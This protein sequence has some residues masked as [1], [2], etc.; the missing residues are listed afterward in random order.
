[1]AKPKLP[2]AKDFDF[3]NAEKNIDGAFY[4]RDENGIFM[5]RSH[6][7]EQDGALDADRAALRKSW[8]YPDLTPP[9]NSFGANP[10]DD[11]KEKKEKKKKEEKEESGKHIPGTPNESLQHIY[12]YTYSYTEYI[13]IYINN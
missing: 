3:A 12:I 11:K 9:R 6:G 8:S 13:Y 5:T 1:M 2:K 4:P 10:E 7:R